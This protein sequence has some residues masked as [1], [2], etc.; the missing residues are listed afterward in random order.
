MKIFDINT[1]IGHWPFRKI[2]NNTP[3]E[4]RALLESK[5]LSGAAV[6][7][8]HGIFY[9]NCH[10][11]NCELNA[12]ISEH[13]D[14]F[15]GIATLN[16]T[17]P[18]W[19]RDLRECVDQFK[20]KVLRLLPLYHNYSLKSAEASAII[21]S[22]GK[23]K[24]PVIIPACIVNFR[25][26]H[27]MDIPRTLEF[28]EFKEAAIKHPETDFIFTESIVPENLFIDSPGNLY[29]EASRYRSAHGGVL[30]NIVKMIG[31][32]HVLFGSGAPFKEITP[33][34]MKLENAEISVAE[35]K[36]ITSGNFKRILKIR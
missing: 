18:G 27:W 26:M 7:N 24:M 20:F 30:A 4:L 9:K 28:S 19:E 3:A 25:Q 5:G 8:T 13:L 2:P 12:A 14:F 33:A 15:T 6:A 22:A 32:D 11:A 16:P 23:L 35:K 31:A 10:D 34:L 36:L 17:Y 29:L 21:S 1:A